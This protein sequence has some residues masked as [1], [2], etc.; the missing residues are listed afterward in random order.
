[1]KDKILRSLTQMLPVHNRG[2]SCNECAACCKLPTRCVFLKDNSDGS[3]RC[4]VYKYRP[5][6]CRKFPRTEKQLALV[7]DKCSFFFYTNKEGD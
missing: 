5:L 2:G 7:K 1:M 4:T 3:G 6:V